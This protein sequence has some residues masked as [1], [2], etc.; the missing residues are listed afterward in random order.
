MGYEWQVKEKEGVKAYRAFRI[1]L[2]LGPSRTITQVARELGV[3]QPRVSSWSRKY[4]WTKRVLA[5][6]EAI[7][8]ALVDTYTGAIKDNQGI[9]VTDA[10]RDYNELLELWRIKVDEIKKNP[11]SIT[12]D[13]LTKLATTRRTIDDVGRRATG[14]PGIIR[15][16]TNK[17]DTSK[18]PQVKQLGWI[19][20]TATKVNRELPDG[21]ND[22]VE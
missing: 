7:T 12:P 2:Q 1:Y 17:D 18:I 22:D 20:G 13:E 10:L 15:E 3:A 19:N 21:Q 11:E 4:G 9:I 6:E 16:Q 14:L 5:V 8:Q